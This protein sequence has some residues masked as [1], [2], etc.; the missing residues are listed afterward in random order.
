MIAHYH[1]QLTLEG[2]HIDI[3]IHESALWAAAPAQTT[4]E[5]DPRLWEFQKAIPSRGSRT[6]RGTVMVRN[7]WPCQDGYLCWRMMTGPGLGQRVR[8]LVEWMDEEGMAG[9]M[10]EV[11]WEEVDLLKLTQEQIDRWEALWIAFFN[12]HTRAELYEEAVRRG[13]LIYPVATV[14]EVMQNRQLAARDFFV[15][16]EHPELDASIVYPSIPFKCSEVACRLQRRAPLIGEH[17]DEIYIRELG[18]SPAE[19]IA[20][21]EI[22]VI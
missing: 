20:L 17:N 9:D 15:L 5:L 7:M 18:L 19:L 16:L 4:S 13:V 14:E 12:T 8:L 3:S 2:Q 22:N 10:M 11:N 6:L 21:K 1:R